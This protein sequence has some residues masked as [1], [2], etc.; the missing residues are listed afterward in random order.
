MG[1]AELRRWGGTVV[2]GADRNSMRGRRMNSF[3]PQQAPVAG[4]RELPRLHATRG[5]IYEMN[6]KFLKD[7]APCNY[8]SPQF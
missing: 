2:N 1:H 5:F 7:S 6:R 3:G 4:T 8:K